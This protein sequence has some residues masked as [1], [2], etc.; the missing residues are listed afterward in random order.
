MIETQGYFQ[1]LRFLPKILLAMVIPF[2]DGIY[3]KIAVWLNDL[4][5]R[6]IF[7]DIM[8]IRESNYISRIH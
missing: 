1:F 3:N 4:G 7:F 2:L 8:N 5:K 6:A